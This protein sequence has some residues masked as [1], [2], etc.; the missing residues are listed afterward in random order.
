[1]SSSTSPMACPSCQS[2]LSAYIDE[3]LAAEDV[4]R[5]HAHLH[6][7]HACSGQLADL[8]TT[9]R[10]LRTLP[11]PVPRPEAWE[12][13]AF[14]LRREG[15][16]RSPWKRRAG[17]SAGAAAAVIVGTMWGYA[18]L[19]PPPQSASLEAYWREHAV[20]T[21][22]EEPSVSSGAP[23]LEVMEA[24]YHMQGSAR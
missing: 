20:F 13:V 12:A 16:L 3:Q 4:W 21:S 18:R 15:L 7:C 22:Q 2:L 10:A 5:V 9:Q 6:A 23:A 11:R 24:N 14:A 17:W 8:M 1:M 19:V